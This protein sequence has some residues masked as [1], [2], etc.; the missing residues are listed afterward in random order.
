R[1]GQI[2]GATWLTGLLDDAVQSA[3]L[4]VA[5]DLMLF[6]KSLHTL[7]GVSAEVD[8]SRSPID[9][10]LSCEFLRQFVRDWPRRWLA[11]PTSRD[12]GTRISNLDLMWASWSGPATLA[13]FWV[14]RGCDW[15]HAWRCHEESWI[16]REAVRSKDR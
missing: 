14:G 12:Y 8:G 6:R 11:L 2:P 16:G 9:D 4:R 15:Y 13:R 1:E 7:A 5:P 10:V 3:R